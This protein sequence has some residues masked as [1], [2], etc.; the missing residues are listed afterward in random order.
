MDLLQT[1]YF[2]DP[3]QVRFRLRSVSEGADL[4]WI[5]LPGG[6]GA[7]SSYF[8]TLIAAVSFPGRTWS[9]DLPGNGSN[10]LFIDF[11]EWANILPKSLKQFSKPILV[12]HSFGGMY[13]LLFPE[14]EEVLRGFISLNSAPCQWLEEA[15]SYA[16][17]FDVPD[18]SVEMQALIDHPSQETFDQAL[19]ACIPYYFPP[20]S[21]EKGKE[22]FQGLVFRYEPA[23]WWQEKVL[24]INFSATWIPEKIPMLT[25]GA[26]YDCI[27]PYTLFAKDAR[28]KRDNIQ[29][30]VI[31]DAGH[32]PWIEKPEEVASAVETFTYSL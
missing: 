19:E 32:I 16:K 18:L 2:Y 10:G 29:Q 6:P 31:Q 27:C 9:M 25:V 21:L 30:V 13:P 11:D 22:M 3:H 17:G 8:D 1:P 7:D 12:G 15:V 20:S 26:T 4:D 5:F 23:A 24:E 14:L 28:F